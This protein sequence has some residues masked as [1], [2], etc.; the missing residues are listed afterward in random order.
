RPLNTRALFRFFGPQECDP[1]EQQ[2]EFN[3]LIGGSRVFADL[4]PDTI[5]RYLAGGDP[6]GAD[7]A[8][9]KTSYAEITKFADL[10]ID[11]PFLP[12]GIALHLPP[13]IPDTSPKDQQI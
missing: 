4:D 6:A 12:K 1:R 11:Q 8:A 2:A 10:Y 7:D 9:R 3:S 5:H 13:A